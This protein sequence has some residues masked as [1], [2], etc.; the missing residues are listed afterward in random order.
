M[1]RRLATALALGIAVAAVTA[2]PGVA[3]LEVAVSVSPAKGI[4]DRPVEVLVRTF[5]PIGGDAI[6]LPPP[7][8]GYPAPSGL[9]NVL[10]PVDYPFDVLARSPTGEELKIDLARDGSDASLW[11]GSFTPTMPGQWWIV[12]RN[13]PTY[14]PI[15]LDVAADDPNSST[16]LI[17]IAA[18]LG[19]LA[20]GLILGRA[21]R[22]S[23]SGD[24][25]RR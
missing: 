15:R 11:R 12:M 22:R 14:A 23:P 25:A 19:G 13:Y 10:Y 7:S 1:K 8:L 5:V 18:L 4:V 9:W 21:M 3:A 2:R 6:D 16:W 17:A 24:I 20:G